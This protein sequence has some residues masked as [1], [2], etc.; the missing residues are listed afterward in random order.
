[1]AY[2]WFAM[3]GEQVPAAEASRA[4]WEQQKLRGDA[5]LQ[6]VRGESERES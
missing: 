2:R 6:Q 4:E 5:S 3:T 1:M